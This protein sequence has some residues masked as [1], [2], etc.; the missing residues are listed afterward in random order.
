M[1]PPL[2]KDQLDLIHKLY[3]KDGFTFGRDKLY[4]Y[5]TSNYP[6]YK[7]S[8]NQVLDF[9]K[10]QEVQQLHLSHSKGTD[11]KS[12]V[13][14]QPHNQIA[15][16]LVD[17][18][19]LEKDKYKWLLNGV[20]LFSRMFYSIP[21]KNKEA[22]SVLEGFKKFMKIQKFKSVRSDRGSEFIS[23]AMKAYCEKEGIIQV[24]S[25]PYKP[26]SNGNIERF[27]QSL[28]RLIQKNI[29]IDS[30]FNWVKKLPMLVDNMNNTIIRM[31]KTT[32]QNIEDKYN[33]DDN[34][35]I[36]TIHEK[37]KKYKS[38][39]TAI[40]LFN[41]YDK[42]R[43]Y[44]PSDK[45]KS[46]QWSQEVYN[47]ETVYKPKNSY[48]AFQYKLKGLDTKYK[49]EDLQKIEF[50]DNATEKIKLYVVSKI[51]KPIVHNNK[52]YYEVL[53]KGYKKET[54]E[55]RD[56]L[57]KDIPKMIN[58]F[59]KA[60]EVKWRLNK[61]KVIVLWNNPNPNPNRNTRGKEE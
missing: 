14:K 27:N 16:D 45:M 54:I 15:I 13:M 49:N 42:V 59:E 36:N 39:T 51:I 40:Q 41:K 6:T 57:L 25:S 21:L 61:Q 32:P 55:P 52:R 53:W 50:V 8:I 30:N 11:I 20:D 4:A 60:Y 5:I 33:N 28:K 26:T 22:S 9:L 37:D 2:T 1:A 47:I 29:S 3:Y 18:S 12:T 38:N 31:M 34:D 24:L 46:L 48:S 17:M 7:I 23:D 58:R 35:Y 44:Q 56:E 10:A 19:N 43:V